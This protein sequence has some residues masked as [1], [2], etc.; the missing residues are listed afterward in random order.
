[1]T[2]YVYDKLCDYRQQ[3][4]GSLQS[5]KVVTHRERAHLVAKK[6]SSEQLGIFSKCMVWTWAEV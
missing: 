2:A 1:M 4:H 5:Q 3:K 6:M